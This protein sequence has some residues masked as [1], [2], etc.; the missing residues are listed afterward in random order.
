MRQLIALAVVAEVTGAGGI[1]PLVFSPTRPGQ[2][3]VD[4]EIGLADELPLRHRAGGD[5]AVN[6]GEV[7][8]HQHALPAP[9]RLPAWDVDVRPQR[10]D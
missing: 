10:D 2:D 6:A 9:V 4:G 1:R 7:I 3:V 5:T 8:P